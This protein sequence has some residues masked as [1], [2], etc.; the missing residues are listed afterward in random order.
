MSY[1]RPVVKRNRIQCGHCLSLIESE[2][3]HD[4]KYCA[5]GRVF[6]DGGKD[7]VRYGVDKDTDFLLLTEYE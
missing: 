7:Y 3:R 4:F 2:H 6:I 5:C 1:E